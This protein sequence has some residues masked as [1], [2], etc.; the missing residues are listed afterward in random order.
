MDLKERI[1]ELYGSE[2]SFAR[3][4]GWT[5]QRLNRVLN[6]QRSMPVGAVMDFSRALDCTV[7]DVIIFFGRELPNG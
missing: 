1:K 3:T 2:A 6:G 5:R 4:I 7:E